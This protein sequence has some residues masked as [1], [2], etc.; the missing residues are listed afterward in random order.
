MNLSILDQSPITKGKT[1][2]DAFKASLE[3]AQVGEQLGYKRYWVTEHHDLAGLAST[4]PEVLLSFIGAKTETIRLGAG[5][6]LLPHYRP[7]K[8]AEVYNTLAVLFPERIDLGIGR[9]P[10]GSAEATMAL[11]TN[12]LE[13][14]R[15]LPESLEELLHFLNNNFPKDHM[16][17][18][19]T[20]APVPLVSPDPWILGTSEKSAILAAKHGLSYAYGHFMSDKDGLPIIKRYMDSFQPPVKLSSPKVILTVSVIC[21]ETSERAEELALSSFVAKIQSEKGEKIP[22]LPSVEEAKHYPFTSEDDLT[23]QNERQKMV[24]G[25]PKEVKQQLFNLQRDYHA[26]EI[27]INT[28]TPEYEDR[29]NSY[30]LIAESS[31]N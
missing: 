21:A 1:A 9:A 11:S 6:V 2:N 8:I 15:R 31:L 28:I 30:S 12:Y 24:I 14:V 5:A 20:A 4:A 29:L 25:N 10:G 7:Y 16:F 19:V 27:M 22:S 18:K 3:L 23:I 13:Q 17:S 26:D